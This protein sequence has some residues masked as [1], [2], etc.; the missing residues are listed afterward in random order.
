MDRKGAH[1]VKRM[2]NTKI[3]HELTAS[4]AGDGRFRGESDMHF[5]ELA[6]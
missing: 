1:G 5:D 3:S 6:K 2:A 4:G